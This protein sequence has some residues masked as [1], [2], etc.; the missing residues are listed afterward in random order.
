MYDINYNNVFDGPH[1]LLCTLET[2]SEFGWMINSE[3]MDKIKEYM[4]I[5]SHKCN[6]VSNYSDNKLV[7]DVYSIIKNMIMKEDIIQV[8]TF[9][10]NNKIDD[11]LDVFEV[12]Q[13]KSEKY[14]KQKYLL[15]LNLGDILI[16]IW[17]KK[18]SE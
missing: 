14:P 9:C 3:T 17:R 4:P 7:R 6:M 12:P 11:W 15:S 10:I 8:D 13:L 18:L 5:V 16:F 2:W 1:T